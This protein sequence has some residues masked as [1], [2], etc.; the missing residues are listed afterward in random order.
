M[1][2]VA[3]VQARF[4]SS[5]L[6]GK[7]CLRLGE[8]TVL[9]EVLARCK[10]IPGIDA[11]CCAVADDGMSAPVAA[12]ARR[13]GATVHLGAVEDVL[14]R[15][16]AAANAMQADIVLRVTSDCPLI[17]P[18]LAGEVL[19]KLDG[20]KAD[21]AANNMPPGFP[22]GLDCEA[23]TLE[24]LKRA[25]EA[26]REKAQREHVTPWLRSAEGIRRVAVEGPGGEFARQRWT[27]D[28]PEDYLFV[29]QVFDRLGGRRPGWMEVAQLVAGEPAL[30]SLNAS[31]VDESRLSLM[32]KEDKR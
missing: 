30:Q 6:P 12:E 28:W 18:A 11:V 21:Y 22:H 23:F 24:A 13:S 14:A 8:G 10:A 7:T 2:S 4:H 3:I 31:R 1:R 27:I 15:Y 19:A 17:D 9:G 16:L 20:G 5:R 25:G 29:H 32:A 26:S